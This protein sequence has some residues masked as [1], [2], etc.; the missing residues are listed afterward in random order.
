[1][2]IQALQREGVQGATLL[3]IGGGLGAIQH[4]LLASGAVEAVD[5]DASQSYLLAAREEAARRGLQDRIRFL[6]GNFVDEAPN[7]SPAD[8]VTLD[9]VICCYDDMHRL[10]DTSASRARRLYG[11][12]FPVDAWWSRLAM[13]LGNLFFRLQRSNYR[14]FIHPTTAVEALIASH[15]FSRRYYARSGW[16]QVAVY[17]R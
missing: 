17:A 15:G 7:L 3:D 1:M 13:R 2:L 6:H 5:M 4:D 14:G 10:V 8:I 11:V 12:V 9:R 16:W